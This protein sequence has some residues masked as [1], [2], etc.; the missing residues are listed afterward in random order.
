MQISTEMFPI[1]NIKVSPELI[2]LNNN[3]IKI[4]QP[5]YYTSLLPLESLLVMK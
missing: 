3:M 2:I 5:Y 1:E 4:S